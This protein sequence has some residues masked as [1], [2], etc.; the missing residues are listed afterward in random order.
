MIINPFQRQASIILDLFIVYLFGEED[1]LYKV[2]IVLYTCAATRAIILD[3]VNNA[4]SK[5]FLQSLTKFISRRGCPSLIISDNGSVFKSDETQTFIANKF[6]KWKFN[7]ES[8]PWWGGMWERLV[9]SVKRCIKKMVGIRKINYVEL[10]TLLFE[11]EAVLNN[12]PICD[13]YDDDMNDVLSPNHLLYG[14]RIE[15]INSNSES[16]INDININ[17][18]MNRIETSITHFWKI[19]R[20]EYVTSIRERQKIT[21]KKSP[22]NIKENDVVIVFDEKQPRHL[23]KLGKITRIIYG[24]DNKIRGAELKIGRTNA[25]INRPVNKLYPLESYRTNEINK[26]KENDI[27]RPKRNAAIVGEVKRKFMSYWLSS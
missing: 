6:I 22:N 13:D 11:I 8:A 15:T 10:Q 12:R 9:G 17:N 1:V 27:P 23:W 18:R 25:I 20:K 14:R 4:S 24:N 7:L 3:A 26:D 21:S 16:E 2:F 19:W 5:T